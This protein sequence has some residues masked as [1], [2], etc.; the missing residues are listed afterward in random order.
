MEN[1]PPLIREHVVHFT[2][3]N[4]MKLTDIADID[5]F[6][7]NFV[8][9]RKFTFVQESIRAKGRLGEQLGEY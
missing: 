2:L 6:F 9:V 7:S 1:Q 5:T 3:V 4:L 8:K